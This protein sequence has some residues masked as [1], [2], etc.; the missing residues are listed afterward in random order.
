MWLLTL[1]WL[2]GQV[3]FTD[4]ASQAGLDFQHV[5]GSRDKAA[6]LDTMSGGV[7]WI[8]YDGDGN[9]DLY[10][11]NGGTWQGQ[12]SGNRDLSNALFRNQ[13]DGTFKNVTAQAG[14]A[15]EHWGMG[16]A[17]ADYDNDGDPD[18]YLC[19]Y[20][21][22]QLFRNNGDGTFSD[23]AK[24]AGVDHAGWGSSASWAD[25]DGD[26]NLDLYVANYV[27]YDLEEAHQRTCS[28]RALKV[29]CGPKGMKGAADILYRNNGDGTFSD[30][31]AS[32]GVGAVPPSF[33]L[34]AIWG[35]TDGDGD[36][37]LYVANDS[38]ANFH[39]VNQGDGTF[40][41]MALMKGTAFSED[42][43]PQAGMG[44][45]LGDY[46]RDS[47]VDLYV[48]H[49]SDDYNT[50]YRNQ[51]KGLYRDQS[52]GS[53][54]AFSSRQMLGWGTQ[55]FDY[56]N[57]GWLDLFVANGHV[58]P[59]VDEFAI[60]TRYLQP[61]LL[62]R[63]TGDGFENV[64][65]SAGADLLVPSASRGAAFADYDNDGDIDIAVNNLDGRPQL[66]QNQGGSQ[67]GHWISLHLRGS[68]DSN[69]DAVGAQ[70]TVHTASY[71]QS[72][73][74]QAG[75][76]FQSSSDLRLHFGLGP[77]ETVDKLTVRWPDGRV[78]E[79]E[80]LS[81]NRFYH[82]HQGGEI[83]VRKEAEGGSRL[84]GRNP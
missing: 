68:G 16:T 57:D 41:D 79:F 64:T 73:Q 23:V 2:A 36:A 59:Q 7:A 82:L 75:V 83:E 29:H 18:L 6:L 26:G 35:D 46:D 5:S 49:F 14:V 3:Q 21:P 80:D 42:G 43:N 27:D 78:Q 12:R 25:Y 67:T 33:G 31:T 13:G 81:A 10:L 37:D 56:D 69:R 52:Y 71:R 54:L 20:G 66:F 44:I 30:V 28:Y 24:A 84:P 45:A 53:G 55:F 48:T 62:Y 8:D 11:V 9:L 63:N 76:S 47:D 22:N 34:G 61:K 17:A 1:F 77:H 74:V 19:N 50:L 51:G 4:V 38:M 58:Y 39:F 40:Q 70:A 65:G 32:S 72:Q 15:G 60:G